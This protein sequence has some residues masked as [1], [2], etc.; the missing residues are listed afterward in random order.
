MLLLLAVVVPCCGC[1][2]CCCGSELLWSSTRVAQT[3][4]QYERMNRL[5]FFRCANRQKREALNLNK[6][7]T[8][9]VLGSRGEGAFGL[10]LFR[11]SEEKE[12]QTRTYNVGAV[13]EVP[14]LLAMGV[15]MFYR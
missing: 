5:A 12:K 3:G 15:W 10:K 9:D 6:G 4:L 8:R 7:I 2:S 14:V 13:G 1:F 11:G